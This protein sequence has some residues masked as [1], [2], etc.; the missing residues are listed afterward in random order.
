MMY[1]IPLYVLGCMESYSVCLFGSDSFHLALHVV[2]CLGIL[3]LLEA[4]DSVVWTLAL[5][6][7]G[8]RL[9]CFCHC[10]Y[11]AVNVCVREFESMC[12]ILGDYK[13]RI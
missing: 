13:P 7:V 11:A 8:E 12:H 2:V 10:E 5:L 3:L 6:L 4:D 1:F 9:G